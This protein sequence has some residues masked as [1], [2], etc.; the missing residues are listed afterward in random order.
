MI[1]ADIEPAF[2]DARSKATAPPSDTPYSTTLGFT[3][4]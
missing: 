4:C 3:P 1:K 2:R